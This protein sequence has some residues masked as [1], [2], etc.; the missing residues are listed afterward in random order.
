MAALCV[1][2]VGGR[3]AGS[4][5]AGCASGGTL[6]VVAHQDDDILFLN[7]NLLHDIR[8]GR[9]VRT[10]YVTAGDANQGQAYW[11]SREAGVQAAY[12]DMAGVTNAW[13][14]ADAEVGEHPTQ[15]VT[16]TAAPNISLMF[17]RLPDGAIDGSGQP[18]HDFESLQKLDTGAISTIHE[19]D[20][21]SSYTKTTLVGTLLTLMNTYKPSSVNTLDYV[22]TYGDGD[23]SDHH[24]VAVLTQ[25]AEQQYTVPHG[26]A[27]Y[28]G[29]GI[30]SKASNV[31][32]SDLRAKMHA[33]LTY[34]QFDADTCN[35]AAR[36]SSRPEGTWFPRQYTVD[37]PTPIPTSAATPTSP[38][39]DGQR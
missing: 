28:Q 1:S 30:A 12:A 2:C 24:A 10:V 34:A 13:T 33:F 18:T 6:N 37:T 22:G 11:S 31:S 16:L 7:P 39:P 17:L 21:S 27:G 26:F 20:N 25:Q 23:H 14:T 36:C 29:Y 9:C 32:G 8:A 4:A 35:T 15:M 5:V 3:A 38:S 19:I